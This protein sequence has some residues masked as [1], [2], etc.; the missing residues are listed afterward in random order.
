MKKA[1]ALVMAGSPG[2]KAHKEKQDA[3]EQQKKKATM[4]HTHAPITFLAETT[5]TKKM[6]TAM[7]E[8]IEKA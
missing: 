6:T 1:R 8:I 7:K 5:R 3:V 2:Y 4:V